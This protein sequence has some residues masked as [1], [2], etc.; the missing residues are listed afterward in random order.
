MATDSKALTVLDEGW[1]PAKVELIK[2]TIAKD[3]T[4]DELAMFLHRCKATGLDPLAR[5][6]HFVKRSNQAVIQT[7]IDGYRLIAD[8]TG[9]YAG[10]DDPQY[11]P[12]QGERPTTATVTVWKLVNGQRCPFTATARWKEYAPEGNQGFMWK[13]MPYLMLGKV[14]EA[15]ALRKA[16]PQDLSGIYVDEEMHQADEPAPVRARVV[17]TSAKATNGPADL[18]PTDEPAT[19]ATLRGVALRDA[20]CL[21]LNGANDEHELRDVWM[22][23]QRHFRRLSDQE[24]VHVQRYKDE[25]KRELTGDPTAAAF[26]ADS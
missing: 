22:E 1:T 21:M 13:R 12:E 7:G 15:L 9:L 26:P 4:E 23:C 14:A 11:G 6:I 16:F 2:R 5:Q 25:C 20:L 8:R 24:K 19:L 10:N 18:P 17:E 3:A